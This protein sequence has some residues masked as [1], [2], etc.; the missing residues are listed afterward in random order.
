MPVRNASA[1]GSWCRRRQ[2]RRCRREVEL[3]HPRVA[4]V[5]RS[6]PLFM[7]WT[8]TLGTRRATAFAADDARGNSS[9]IVP[10]AAVSQLRRIGSTRHRVVIT[11]EREA[12]GVV[13][14]ER[15]PSAFVTAARAGLG[16]A[17]RVAGAPLPSRPSHAPEEAKEDLRPS[18]VRA[19]RHGTRGRSSQ[20]GAPD[21]SQ[22]EN[23]DASSCSCGTSRF[24]DL[25]PA[26]LF[27]TVE[28]Q[29][30]L[31]PSRSQPGHHAVGAHVVPLMVASV[32]AAEEC[33]RPSSQVPVVS[34]YSSKADGHAPELKPGQN[35]LPRYG[36]KAGDH[37][38]WPS[39]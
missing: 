4:A 17:F 14:D 28:V 19:G 3:V 37:G 30:H 12:M 29:Y 15:W 7:D 35:Q 1:V 33:I 38:A 32:K 22:P 18:T 21:L 8:N 27:L 9:R 23:Y 24:A 39:R 20:P 34:R 6:Q 26:G 36:A 11:P 25:D 2:Q 16:V 5:L 31:P 10:R 13:S